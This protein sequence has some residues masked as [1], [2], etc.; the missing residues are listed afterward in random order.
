MVTGGQFVP[1]ISKTMMPTPYA[2]D[3]NIQTHSITSKIC[4]FNFPFELLVALL[5]SRILDVD[6]LNR[7]GLTFAVGN[8]LHGI[9]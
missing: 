7:G 1:R 4:L 6:T 9:L 2:E 8:S 3:L 5:Q